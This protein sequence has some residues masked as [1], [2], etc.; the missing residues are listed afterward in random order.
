MGVGAVVCVGAVLSV[1]VRVVVDLG[2]RIGAILMQ[3]G[4]LAKLYV[5]DRILLDRAVQV[6]RHQLQRNL[7]L[8]QR[9]YLT[10][11][12]INRQP[13]FQ[14]LL[15]YCLALIT[16]VNSVVAAMALQEPN[17]AINKAIALTAWA[18]P[19]VPGKPDL[20]AEIALVMLAHRHQLL[21]KLLLQLLLQFRQP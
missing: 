5:Q 3:N 2:V 14:F 11:L 19:I 4:V 18:D 20:I 10:Q 13:Q 21:R 12:L 16:T 9:L 17:S 15:F 7:L 6:R 1:V 8:N